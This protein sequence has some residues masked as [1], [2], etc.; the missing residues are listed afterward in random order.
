MRIICYAAEFAV[1]GLWFYTALEFGLA[2]ALLQAA[3]VVLTCIGALAAASPN[4][5][6]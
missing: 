5:G 2:V 6:P 4:H 1:S 3:A